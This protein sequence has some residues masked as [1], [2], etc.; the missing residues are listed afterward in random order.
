[1]AKNPTE[2]KAVTPAKDKA[3]AKPKAKKEK[4]PKPEKT[5]D[6]MLAKVEMQKIQNHPRVSKEHQSAVKELHSLLKQGKTWADKKVQ[7]LFAILPDSFPF[8]GVYIHNEALTKIGKVKPVDIVLGSGTNSKDKWITVE[9]ANKD[10][11]STEHV[12][13]GYHIICGT[14][15]KKFI[16]KE[17][18]H[19]NHCLTCSTPPPK[20]KKEKK[21]EEADKKK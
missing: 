11:Q 13:K 18:F 20:P 3:K 12:F 14:C 2:D 21:A 10:G 9:Q 17:P 6:E 5:I 1:M 15:H 16:G 4:K 7:E 8:C 19:Q